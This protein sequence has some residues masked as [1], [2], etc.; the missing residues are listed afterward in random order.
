MHDDMSRTSWLFPALLSV[1]VA[2]AP[3]HGARP[4]YGGTLRVE[5]YATMRSL[6][7]AATPVDGVEASFRD[8]VTPLFFESLVTID[9]AGGLRPALA[10]AWSS[11]STATRWRFT[12]RTGVTFHD[13]TP[14]H[15]TQVVAVLRDQLSPAAVMAD[16]A[17]V[18]I[19]AGR[20]RSDLLWE[21]AQPRRAI[22]VRAPDG[23]LVGTGP[24]RV[25][26][27][28]TARLLLAA[29]EGYWGGRPFVD[30]IRIEL[31]RPAAAQLTNLETGRADL[32]TVRATD[33]RRVAQQ[34]LR[35]L[36]SQPSEL[37]ALVFEPDRATTSEL[38]LRR[39][40]ASAIRRDTMVRGLLQGHGTA[41]DALLPAWLSGYPASVVA[42]AVQE[43]QR[44]AAAALPAARRSLVVRASA[45][46]PIAV[47]VAER[48]AVDTR[49]AGFLTTAQVP[50]GLAPRADARLVRL[51]LA[52]TSPER[53][54]AALMAALGPRT[55][56]SA[57]R[58][59]A[60]APGAPLETVA[61]VE[62]ALLEQFVVVPVVHLP[63][64]YAVSE[65]VDTF[66]GRAISATG[67][68][69][70]AD[71]WLRPDAVPRR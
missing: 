34:Q 30:A 23:R 12:I 58:E 31:A 63:A 68:W 71:V 65:R 64:L 16:G 36:A 70:L 62:R 57:T 14:L 52:I 15:P 55:L 19:D 39:A 48:I 7:P 28:E 44:R 38:A 33:A 25:E 10:T 8:L 17:A 46:D 53:S 69:D 21:L 56:N 24:F 5:T 22:A 66:S 35:I 3:I 67:R 47:A 61:R 29:H 60:P 13:G 18:V 49:E 45:A 26:R 43:G 32:V 42:P 11:D 6:D 2:A 9:P 54:L 40:F 41:A 59:P 1:A 37:I 4:R 51:P 20:E 50:T 27:L